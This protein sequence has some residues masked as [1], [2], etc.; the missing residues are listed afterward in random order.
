MESTHADQGNGATAVTPKIK[1]RIATASYEGTVGK[2]EFSAGYG[3]HIVEVDPKKVHPSILELVTAAGA[4][5]I[6]Q[7]AYSANS[8]PVGAARAMMRRL[9]SGDWRPGYPHREAEP[10]V[11]TQ[12]LAT[13]LNKPPAYIEDVYLPAYCRKH[14]IEAGPARRRL[15]LHGAIAEL[16]AKITAERAAKA[17][18]VAKKAPREA[19]DLAV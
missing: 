3:G 8:D 11:L 14:D 16:I 1:K 12:A 2:I 6:V 7:T 13:H 9:E 10:D 5:S 15:R 19:V 18:A 4:V 17:L